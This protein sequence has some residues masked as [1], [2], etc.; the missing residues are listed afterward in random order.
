MK[1]KQ[2]EKI[3]QVGKQKYDTVHRRPY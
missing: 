1:L 3:K 2:L